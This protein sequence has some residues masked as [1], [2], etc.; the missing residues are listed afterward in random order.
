M[1]AAAAQ[2]CFRT[3][4]QTAATQSKS[5]PLN[6]APHSSH[7]WDA[8][9][10]R[11]HPQFRNRMIFKAA[12]GDGAVESADFFGR[13]EIHSAPGASRTARRRAITASRRSTGSNPTSYPICRNTP[14][15]WFMQNAASNKPCCRRL[16]RTARSRIGSQDK[17]NHSIQ[18]HRNCGQRKHSSQRQ[19]Q[20]LVEKCEE[21]RA[22]A[23]ECLVGRPVDTQD[24]MLFGS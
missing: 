18:R 5:R 17:W 2:S 3:H 14:A 24:E 22:S 16:S 20:S 7:R 8:R 10:P 13:N 21:L 1:S 12:D 4:S 23:L 6:S 9:N 11:A 19:S 15:C